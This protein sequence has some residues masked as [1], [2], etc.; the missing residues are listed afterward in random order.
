MGDAV[1]PAAC[2]GCG[3]GQHFR[4]GASVGAV[5][6]IIFYQPRVSL[7]WLKARNLRKAPGRSRMLALI[8]L[9]IGLLFAAP[10]ILVDHLL[11]LLPLGVLVLI[12][13]WINSALSAR[14]RDALAR[15]GGRGAGDWR[16]ASEIV[17]IGGLALGAPAAYYIASGLLGG[18]AAWL[19][20][21]SALYFISSVFYVQMRVLS[22]NR[23]KADAYRQ[24][25]WYCAGYHLVLL[26]GLA[27]LARSGSVNF[28]VLI[29]FTP[30]LARALFHLARPQGRLSLGRIGAL[31]IVYSAVFLVFIAL[32]FRPIA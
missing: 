13:L 20:L 26:M 2:R 32:A 21:L 15:G 7:G 22:C 30:A 28:L 31:E 4:F 11:W 24:A 16:A 17:G 25:R 1:R 6:D 23:R 5:D 8:Y 12:L 29:A 3:G 27:A 19:W 14:G 10:L 9:A 18:V